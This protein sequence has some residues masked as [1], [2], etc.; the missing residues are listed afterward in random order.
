MATDQEIYRMY[1]A[2]GYSDEV[3][4]RMA[5]RGEYTPGSVTRE[6]AQEF[7]AMSP[8]QRR[9]MFYNEYENAAG[10]IQPV[11]EYSSYESLTDPLN[12]LQGMDAEVWRSLEGNP[13]INEILGSLPSYAT[14]QA[15]R[16]ESMKQDYISRGFT[17]EEAE[18]AVALDNA[19]ATHIA[20][21]ASNKAGIQLSQE[22]EAS[23]IDPIKWFNETTGLSAIQDWMDEQTIQ[24]R[25]NEWVKE[26]LPQGFNPTLGLGPRDMDDLHSWLMTAGT[27]YLGANLGADAVEAF[28][29]WQAANAGLEGSTVASEAGVG[30]LETPIYETVGDQVIGRSFDLSGQLGNLS[31]LPQV[32]GAELL[33]GSTPLGMTAEEVALLATEGAGGAGA[34][35]QLGNLAE[36]GVQDVVSQEFNYDFGEFDNVVD[37]GEYTN[38]GDDGGG[39]WDNVWDWAKGEAKDVGGSL[40]DT[41]LQGLINYG[42]NEAFGTTPEDIAKIKS[43]YSN[44]PYTQTATTG[45]QF[46]GELP[47]LELPEGPQFRYIPY[48]TEG[49]LQNKINDLVASGMT[50]EQAVNELGIDLTDQTINLELAPEFTAPE[51]DT[52]K[53]ASRAQEIAGPSTQRLQSA[54]QRALTFGRSENPNVQARATR[55]ALAGYGEGLGDILS[56]A[57]SAAGTEYERQYERELQPSLM[58][59]QTQLEN[60][61]QRN[62]LALQQAQ[63]SYGTDVQ[64]A[65]K[66]YQALLD[67]Y[68]KSG[69]STQ[70]QVFSPNTQATPGVLPSVSTPQSVTLENVNKTMPQNAVV[71]SDENILKYTQPSPF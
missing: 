18:A 20:N 40:L 66:N 61:R 70:Q 8:E 13:Q 27:A 9:D 59:Y 36:G 28:K 37:L 29:A 41:G 5:E 17:P 38:F 55:E 33:S 26:Q 45:T 68:F 54:V 65:L 53:I 47:T 50:P 23:K 31:N 62:Q 64:E 30:T 44:I 12:Y 52:R 58:N 51:Y 2:A 39:F 43:K 49:E 1:I 57:R 25:V 48:G 6:K 7:L 15:G 4:K 60:I 71:G 67:R 32:T 42:L 34:L 11:N 3:A 56:G 22:R 35:S 69:V 14:D 10:G 19:M 63:Q 24:G 21:I 46:V 16:Y